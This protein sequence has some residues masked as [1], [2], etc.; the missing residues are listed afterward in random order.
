MNMKPDDWWAM[1]PNDMT[2]RGYKDMM[3]STNFQ[4][5]DTWIVAQTD[6]IWKKWFGLGVTEIMVI[7]DLPRMH[8]NTPNDSRRKFL[9]LNKE[10]WKDAPNQTIEIVVQDDRVRV[11]TP[12]QMEK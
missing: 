2:R 5:G 11:I 7:A 4:N 8:D 6:P 9:K 1:P 10:I 3:I 12:M